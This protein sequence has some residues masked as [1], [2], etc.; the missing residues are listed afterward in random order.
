MRIGCLLACASCIAANVDPA[1]PAIRFQNFQSVQNLSL[2]GDAAVSGTALR[3]TRARNH[4]SGAVW[5]RGKQPIASG[6]ETTFQ[7]RLTRQGGLGPGADGLAFVLQNS[8][9][10]A[11]GGRGSAGGFAVEDANYD[12]RGKGIP[13][14]IAVFFDTYKNENEGDPSDN[15]VS[16]CT[17]GT[18]SD[19]RWPPARLAFTPDLRVSLKDRQVHTARIVFR[20]PVLSVFLDASSDPVLQAAVDVSMVVDADGRAWVGFTASTGGGYQNHDILR[21]DF[22]SS[23]VSSN[24]SVID[25]DV[26]FPVAACLPNHNLCTPEHAVVEKNGGGYHIVLPANAEWGASIANLPLGQAV[27]HNARGVVCWDVRARGSEGCSGP[28]GNGAPA[29]T[30]FLAEDAP[31]G[32]LIISTHGDRV[33]FSVNGR[34]GDSFRDNEGFFEFDVTGK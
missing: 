14:S 9:P 5:F 30:G 19:M 2:L 7:F 27:I 18:P 23:A 31:P 11:L 33:W 8:G 28:S 20:P 3:L 32:A 6:F 10:D 21:W 13:W 4:R 22:S 12:H 25:S 15:Y 34:Q 17:R 24:I 29:G 16:F 1:A 26:T